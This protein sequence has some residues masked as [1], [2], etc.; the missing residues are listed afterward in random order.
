MS[1]RSATTTA[2][3]PLADAERREPRPSGFVLRFAPILLIAPLIVV[4]ALLDGGAPP[5]VRSVAAILVWWAVLGAVAFSLAPRERV[6]PAAVACAALL[7]AFGLFAGLSLAWAPSAER[8]FAVGD[9]ALFYT[10]VLLLPVLLAR[11]GDAARW[12]DALAV[13]TVAVAALALGQRLFPNLLPDGNLAELLPAAAKRLSY[14]LGYWN[15]LAIFVALGFPLLLRVA[16]AARAWWWRAAAIAPLPAMAGV[17]YLTSSRGGVAVAVLASAAFVLLAGRVLALLAGAAAA[18]G[19]AAAVAVLAARDVL[20]DGPFDSSTASDA[21]VEAALLLAAVC[22]V[23]ALAYGLLSRAVALRPAVPRAAWVALGVVAVVTLVAADPAG[24]FEDFTE[25]PP[26]APGAV[27]VGAHLTSGV[28]SGRWQFWSAAADQWREHPVVGN[29]AGSFEPW[30]AQHGTLDWFVRNAHS[31]WLE[32]LG[33]LGIVGLLLLAGAFAV[34]VVA[35]AGRLAGRTAE[36]RA[37]VAALLA[38]VVGFAVG[39]AIDWVWQIPVVAILALVPLGLLVGP[40]TARDRGPV[41]TSRSRFGVRAA[42][43]VGAWVA[44]CAQVLPFLASE[45]VDAS[46]RAAARGELGEALDRARSAQTIQP[47]ASSPRLQLALVREEAGQI[48]QARRAIAAAIARDET[49]WRLRVVAARLAVK[50]GDVD[51]A[52]TELARARSLNPRSRLLGRTVG[53]DGTR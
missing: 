35:G 26:E 44:I 6:A 5:P 9:Q 53:P 47:W 23:L 3:R 34:G 29:G 22:L 16:V 41:P 45:E 19:C 11:R 14:P 13:A 4:E 42:L 30:W 12:A 32:T 8:A 27:D 21:G 2:A 25:R 39:A 51:A 24:R 37:T 52:R 38:V 40:A 17:I 20:T 7:G 43:I 31:L 36:E 49:D 28:G 48:R 46:R 10:G 15:G 50:A 33:E 18:A 1:S